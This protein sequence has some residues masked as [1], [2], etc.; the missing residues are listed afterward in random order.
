MARMIFGVSRGAMRVAVG[1][2]RRLTAGADIRRRAAMLFRAGGR[3]VPPIVAGASKA[4]P[5]ARE[6]IG[7][8]QR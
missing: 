2:S 7:L 4:P 6:G 3:E 8:C 1:G 5:A